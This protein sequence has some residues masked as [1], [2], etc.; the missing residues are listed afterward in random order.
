MPSAGFSGPAAD[1]DDTVVALHRWLAQTPSRMLAVA[2]P[3]LVGDRR[4]INQPGTND[5]YPNW[6]LPLAGPD[7]TPLDLDDIRASSLAGPLFDA[8][9][10]D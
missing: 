5:E 2:L 6:R 7:G 1:V 8:L 9:R 3:D 10:T 4:A